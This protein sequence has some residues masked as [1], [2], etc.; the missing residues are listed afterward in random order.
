[1][2]NAVAHSAAISGRHVPSSPSRVPIATVT[3]G[4]QSNRPGRTLNQP[5][6]ERVLM[7]KKH[8]IALADMIRDFNA[9]AESIGQRKFDANQIELMAAFC[10]QQN[11]QFNESRWLSYIA[12]ECGP[13]GGAV[14]GRAA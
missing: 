10:K 2:S 8:F 1:M 3:D 14:K 9:D 12:G 5:M 13:N 11:Y 6:N 4:M 7:T